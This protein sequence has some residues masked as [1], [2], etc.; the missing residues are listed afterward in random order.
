[1]YPAAT[2]LSVRAARVGS[3]NN[4]AAAC[5]EVEQIRQP[6]ENVNGMDVSVGATTMLLVFCANSVASAE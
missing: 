1:M 5:C 4:W 6:P 3:R 2:A